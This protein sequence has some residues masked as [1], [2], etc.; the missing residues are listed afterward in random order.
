MNLLALVI[1]LRLT[2][3]TLMHSIYKRDA[4]V[5]LRWCMAARNC[6]YGGGLPARPTFHEAPKHVRVRL[7]KKQ[8]AGLIS[9]PEIVDQKERALSTCS[10][11]TPIYIRLLCITHPHHTQTYTYILTLI[12]RLQHSNICNTTDK[13]AKI[14]P[15]VTTKKEA[16]WEC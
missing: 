12:Y 4:V 10:S 14:S 3:T 11:S 16:A 13:T 5:I 6:G 2:K 15:V 9:T 7:E 1:K 8:L